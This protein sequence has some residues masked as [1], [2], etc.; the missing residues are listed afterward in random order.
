MVGMTF[1]NRVEAPLGREPVTIIR[2]CHGTGSERVGIVG[3]ELKRA[4]GG[5]VHCCR[6]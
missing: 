3:I 5:L 1:Q 6:R 2:N 4:T